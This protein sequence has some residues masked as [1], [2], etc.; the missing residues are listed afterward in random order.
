MKDI[1][2]KIKF[3]FPFTITITK[4]RQKE[5][6]AELITSEVTSQ[7]PWED[8]KIKLNGKL[9][10]IVTIDASVSTE[11]VNIVK[12]WIKEQLDEE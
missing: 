7:L 2:L 4:R 9:G 3:P 1:K 11:I 10:G 8:L 5:I 12:E 6:L